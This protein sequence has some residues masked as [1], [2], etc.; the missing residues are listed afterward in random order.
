MMM[1]V[2]LV[3]DD[4]ISNLLNKKTLQR[5]GMVNEVHTALNGEEAITL[6][7][8][9]FQGSLPMPDIIL[10][11]LNMP[12]MDGFSFI[13]AFN[14]LQLP[15]KDKVRIIIVTSSQS[16]TDIDRAKSLGIVHFLTKPITE[17]SLRIALEG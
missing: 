16:P 14:K 8:D 15:D 1:K 17:N 4:Q 2:L 9:Y 10:L 12:I 3:D 13:E 7:N 11:D 5:V 6:L